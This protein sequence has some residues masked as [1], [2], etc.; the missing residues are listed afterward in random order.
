M[1]TKLKP[2]LFA[3]DVLDTIR[4]FPASV[5]RAAGF[6]LEKVQRGLPPDDWKPMPTVGSGVNEI[7]IRDA[8]GAFRVIYVAKLEAAVCVL[9]AFQKKTGKTAKLDLELARH[10]LRELLQR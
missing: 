2:I 9:H 8:T 3:G 10:R 4:A 7:R 1:G 6:Q 5:R